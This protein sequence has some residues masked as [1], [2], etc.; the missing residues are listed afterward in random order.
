VAQVIHLPTLRDLPD[1][2][3]VVALCDVSALVLEKVGAQW[4]AAK[5]YKD[6]RDL[7]A[8]RRVEAVLVANPHV[9]HA[10]VA[11]DAMTAGKHAL[12]EKPMCISLKEAD[13][14][15]DCESR[16]GV[17]VQ[18]GFMRRYAPAF[19]EAVERVSAIRSE[20][21][22]ARVHDVIGANRMIIDST[23]TVFR[24]PDSTA[25]LTG[26]A[27]SDMA[28]ATALAIGAQAPEKLRAYGLLLGLSSH[29]L[30]AM[31]ELLG[32]PEKVLYA[33]QRLGG[34]A[35]TAAFDYGRFV[36]QFE[37]AVDRIPHFDAH[38]EIST[39]TQIVRVDYDTPYVRHLPARLTVIGEH[40]GAGVTQSSSFPTRYD[41]F[42]V[43]WREFHRNIV[44]EQKPKTSIDDARE[45]LEIFREMIALMP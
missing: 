9:Y 4:P 33:A 7:V 35:I 17:T 39:E 36:C 31:R 10:G 25:S 6:H 34:R 19:A 21:I 16:S 13:A 43:E 5:R 38:I 18:V 32:R 24:D 30:S 12:I 40:G 42:G 23:S 11:L 26:K 27:E 2:F 15:I 41:S 45:D 20:V 37:T 28:T 1:L 44:Q 14:L 8:D 3:E 22:L 29:D